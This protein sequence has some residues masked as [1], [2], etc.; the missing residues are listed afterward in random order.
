MSQ[1]SV[2]KFAGLAPYDAT[3]ITQ[4]PNANLSNEQA[5]SLLATGYLKVTTGTGVLSSQPIPIPIADGGTNNT[6]ATTNGAAYYDG[7]KIN[8]TAAGTNNTVLHG[9]TG[10]APSY[11]VV[12]LT[13]DVGASILPI[14]NGGT[15][16]SSAYTQGSVIFSDGTKLTQNN[17]ELFWDNTNNHLLIGGTS[18][19]NADIVL[20]AD[21]SAVFNEQGNDADFRIEGDTAT[22][23]FVVDAGLDAVQIGTTVAGN[24]ADFRSTGVVFNEDGGQRQLRIEGDTQTHL[25]FVD[26]Q[27]GIERV[28]IRQSSP[29]STLHINGGL[30]VGVVSKSANY[31]ATGD[32]Y[33]ILVTAGIGTVTITLPDA[34]TQLGQTLF[35]KKMDA[36]GT[37]TIARAGSDTIEG[38]TSVSMTT[39]YASRTLVAGAGAMWHV[40]MQT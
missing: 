1:S 15:N 14:A 13:A 26:G 6:T 34:A 36:T 8:T 17:A 19:A 27:G 2:K 24:I 32:D 21:G 25:V 22:Q 29:T 28:G 35:I 33:A 3:Y 23:L 10:A 16:N 20:K 31:T 37:V 30:G 18:A 5:L 12:A 7:S 40:Q 4:T 9:N 11:S 38:A 39:Q